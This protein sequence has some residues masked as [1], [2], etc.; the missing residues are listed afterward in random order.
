MKKML[1][2]Y[3]ELC[4]NG[5]C[6][7]YL[8]EAEK[9]DVK[10][11]GTM[12]LTG[13]IQRAKEP[14][15]NNRI[16]SEEILRREI[17]NY[18]KLIQENRALGELDHPDDSVINLKNVSHTMVKVWWDGNN[19]MGKA[20]ILNT[21]SGKILQSLVESGI[22][23]GISSR[24]MGS[25]SEAPDGRTVVEDDFNL[26]CFDFVSEPSTRGAFMDMRESKNS[27]QENKATKINKLLNKIIQS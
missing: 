21:P 17:D 27:I 5:T 10:D 6:Q 25:V 12:Y 14:N 24:G 1:N 23:L 13:V 20:K 11:N 18:Q 22:K 3:F 15:G 9:K 7:D 16:Y 4:P 19:V 2:E 26:I 8:T